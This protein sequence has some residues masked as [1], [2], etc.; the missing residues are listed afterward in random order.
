MGLLKF[1]E[2]VCVQTAIYWEPTGTDGFGRRTFADPIE[3]RVRWDDM[4]EAITTNDGKEII[5]RAVILSP[6]VM[7]PEGFLHLGSFNDFMDESHTLSP[8]QLAGSYE[9]KKAQFNPLF[10]S[11]KEFVRQYWV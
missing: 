10:R 5:S 8:E 9:I 4:A 1:V 3:V 6:Y 7:K 11:R 2:S